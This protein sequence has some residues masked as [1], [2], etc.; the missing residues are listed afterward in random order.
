[1]ATHAA[2][3]KDPVREAAAS[4]SLHD[5]RFASEPWDLWG[6]F[7]E[8]PG[9]LHSD[10]DGGFWIFSRAEQIRYAGAH[11]ELF[12]AR[13][14]RALPPHPR[15][16]LPSDA[17]GSMHREYRKIINPWMNPAAVSYMEPEVKAIFEQ[18]LEPLVSRT[19]IDIVQEYLTPAIVMCGLKWLNWPTEDWKRFRDWAHH[20]LVP[21]AGTVEEKLR[22]WNELSEWVM[23]DIERRRSAPHGDVIDAVIDAEIQGRPIADEEIMQIVIS[24]FLGAGHTTGSTLSAAFHYLA[25]H[26]EA[27]N[28]LRADPEGTLPLAIEEF[29]RTAG[30]IAYTARTVT[31]DTTVDGR[32]MKQGDRVALLMNS[33]N[34]DESDFPNP[35]ELE[36]DRKPNRHFGFGAGPHKCAGIPF[37]RMM[38]RFAIEE[39]LAKLGDFHIAD[40][41]AVRWE[42]AQVRV[43]TAMPIIHRAR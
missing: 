29:V 19:E 5:Q 17:D 31:E 28:M 38:M 11:E 8:S 41:S 34:R 30:T 15:R 39:A 7:R 13:Q 40:E 36:L 6:G 27:R 14:G 37:A 18:C 24:I 9:V 26:P 4:Y 20:M 23:A 16:L 43:C 21:S 12:C 42:T 32:P 1:M 25:N 35:D 10:Q 22:A 33:A 3:P 2:E